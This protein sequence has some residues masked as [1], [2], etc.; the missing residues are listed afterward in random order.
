MMLLMHD[1][2]W[3]LLQHTNM[4]IALNPCPKKTAHHK[5]GKCQDDPLLILLLLSLCVHCSGLL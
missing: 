3:H 4:A 2:T 5:H 1:N